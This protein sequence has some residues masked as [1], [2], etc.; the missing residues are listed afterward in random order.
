MCCHG[1]RSSYHEHSNCTHVHYR[2]TLKYPVMCICPCVHCLTCG[3]VQDF[4]SAELPRN[5]LSGKSESD[6]FDEVAA[7]DFGV[8]VVMVCVNCRCDG[9]HGL[10]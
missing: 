9:C 5:Q 6:R 7:M 1:C 8:M 3:A 2:Q 4:S 10:C